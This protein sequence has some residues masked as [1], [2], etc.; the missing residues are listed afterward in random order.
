MSLEKDKLKQ[1]LELADKVL[2]APYK[3]EKIQKVK[4]MFGIEFESTIKRYT[5][6]EIFLFSQFVDNI[7]VKFRYLNRWRSIKLPEIAFLQLSKDD[8]DKLLNREFEKL[9]KECQG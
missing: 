7:D 2:N 3:L 8:I 4:K 5:Y 6:R 9:Q 1:I